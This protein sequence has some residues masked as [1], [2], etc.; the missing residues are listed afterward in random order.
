M[1]S[2]QKREPRLSNDDAAG[3]IEKSPSWLNKQRAAG[4]GPRFLKVGGRVQYRVSDLDAYLDGCA[5]ETA[6]SRQEA[7]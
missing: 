1:T 3:Y 4:R 2:E 5:R 6:E 7:A